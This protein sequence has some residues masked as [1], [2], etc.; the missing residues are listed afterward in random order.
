MQSRRL[1]AVEAIAST[2][3]GFGVSLALT[4]TVL[5][6]FGYH[7]TASHAWGITAIY[8]AASIGRGYIVRRVFNAR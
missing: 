5:P 8:T 2:A 7:V 1:S 6:A 3:I 4:F